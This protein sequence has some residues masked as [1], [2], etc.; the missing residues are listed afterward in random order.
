LIG[1]SCCASQSIG[2]SI[3]FHRDRYFEESF[4]EKNTLNFNQSV[5]KLKYVLVGNGVIEKQL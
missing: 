2:Q 3:I 1:K 5:R 4:E